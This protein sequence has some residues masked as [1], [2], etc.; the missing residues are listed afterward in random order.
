MNPK[1]IFNGVREIRAI[2]L[3]ES[4]KIRALGKNVLCSD[5]INKNYSGNIPLFLGSVQFM[6]TKYECQLYRMAAELSAF[7]DEICDE[8]EKHKKENKDATS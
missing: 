1:E 3:V 5:E 7:C 4:G 6:F 8:L 2:L